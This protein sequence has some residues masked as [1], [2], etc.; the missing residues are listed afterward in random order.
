MRGSL[1]TMSHSPL[2]LICLVSSATAAEGFRY[3]Q[4]RISTGAT[5]RQCGI[6]PRV[7]RHTSVSTSSRSA[8]SPEPRILKSWVLT[9][10]TELR[11]SSTPFARNLAEADLVLP[12]DMEMADTKSSTYRWVC[13]IENTESA[14]AASGCFPARYT[15]VSVQCGTPSAYSAAR[16]V[17][18]ASTPARYSNPGGASSR[19][20]VARSRRTV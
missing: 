5:T 15:S 8:G 1:R 7:E 2:D 12:G 18:S 10:R 6:A 4:S 17:V 3:S 13:S 14:S 19:M 16:M 20:R 11:L 9:Y